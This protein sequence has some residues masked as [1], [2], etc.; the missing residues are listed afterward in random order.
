MTTPYY[1]DDLVTLFHGD[2]LEETAWLGADVLV[3]DPPYGMGY[4][5]HS[6]AGKNTA[7]EIVGDNDTTSRDRMLSVWGNKPAMVFGSWRNERPACD[8]VII[9]DKGDEASLGH[10]VFFSAFEEIYVRGSGWV[11]PRR[12][13][14]LRVR[15]MS[16]GGADRKAYGH[17]TPKPIGLMEMI[18]SHCPPL[19]TIADPFA[20]SGSTLV[21]ARNLGRHAIAVE[22][23]ERYCELIAKR[24]AQQAF[25]FGEPTE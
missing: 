3:T 19:A 4:Y 11:G 12:P 22:I 14:V 15:G 16:R 23:E 13:N 7:L 17:P 2:C 21:A 9:W 5:L 6:R 1:Q 8:Q 20:G 25:N 18:V 10:P 24:L